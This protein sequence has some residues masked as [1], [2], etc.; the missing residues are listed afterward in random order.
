[1]TKN[2]IRKFI[3][4]WLAGA[5]ALI[6]IFLIYTDTIF[7]GVLFYGVVMHALLLV[8]FNTIYSDV[9]FDKFMEKI[10][11]NHKTWL[12]KLFGRLQ[13]AACF[14]ISLYILALKG[15]WYL[16]ILTCTTIVL[17]VILVKMVRKE[18]RGSKAVLYHPHQ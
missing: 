6:G 18:L 12:Q 9:A 17:C 1:M 4:D 15:R 16:F 10:K 14:G 11:M 5:I 7:I 2:E 13:V 8:Y 3:S